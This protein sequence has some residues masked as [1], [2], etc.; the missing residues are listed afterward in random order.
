M[1][2]LSGIRGRGTRF[3]GLRAINISF[4]RGPPFFAE[5]NE[6]RGSNGFSSLESCDTMPGGSRTNISARLMNND[7][8]FRMLARESKNLL[9][10]LQNCLIEHDRRKKY[11]ECRIK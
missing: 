2:T 1:A 4:R 5:C 7:S 8:S 9:K 10:D 3:E 11:S 6:A